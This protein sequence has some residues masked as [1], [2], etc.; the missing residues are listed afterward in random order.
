[1]SSLQIIS[2]RDKCIFIFVKFEIEM[3]ANTRPKVSKS[4]LAQTPYR[5]CGICNKAV[6]R[7]SSK[8]S[9]E[10]TLRRHRGKSKQCG[11]MIHGNVEEDHIFEDGGMSPVT[12]DDPLEEDFIETQNVLLSAQDVGLKVDLSKR[13]DFILSEMDVDDLCKEGR[14]NCIEIDAVSPSIDILEKQKKLELFFDSRLNPKPFGN[15]RSPGGKA[16]TPFK[17]EDDADLLKL[18][19]SCGLSDNQ[20]DLMIETF[21]KILDRWEVRIPIH[22]D[23]TYMRSKLDRMVSEHFPI[24]TKHFPF[25][26]D[27]FGEYI[28][29][30]P[31]KPMIGTNFDIK[32]ILAE[33]LLECDPSLFLTEFNGEHPPQGINAN[34]GNSPMWKA[35]CD[36]MNLYPKIE[37]QSPIPICLVISSDEAMASRSKSEQ[38]LDFGILNCVGT[39]F[40]KHL[41]GY[42]PLNLPYSEATL[43]QLLKDRGIN[44]KTDHERILRWTK[45]K[46]MMEFIFSVF[47]PVTKL[48][49]N[50]FEVLIGQGA[51][52]IKRIAFFHVL[53]ISGDGMF[54]DGIAGT[55]MRRLGMQCRLCTTRKMYGLTEPV[56]GYV[57]RD[58]FEHAWIVAQLEEVY[59]KRWC[60]FVNKG[61]EEGSLYKYSLQD[62]EFLKLGKQF[63]LVEG[64]NCL[65]KFF[66]YWRGR[67][68]SSLHQAIPPDFLHVIEKG[69]LEKTIQW[70]LVV[71][72]LVEEI[73]RKSRLEN[74]TEG[75]SLLDARIISFPPRQ[76]YWFSR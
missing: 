38:P 65:Y 57:Y 3:L 68:I 7:F 67:G 2:F 51:D 4:V 28:R 61:A 11:I 45:R 44:F 42:N 60:W 75:N 66:G 50:C 41:V 76:S 26:K 5:V 19:T 17:W 52:Q 8:D 74:Y 13:S 43:I 25:N 18:A 12:D 39:S 15:L 21:Q 73:S 20:G 16:G 35:I 34:F 1:M 30:Q 9:W 47:D 53:L 32:S 63:G 56:G 71:V 36:D 22:K 37:G 62:K 29:G 72:G 49:E 23:F 40:K 59:V 24:E 64:R 69:F 6:Y 27:I 33:A 46:A 10:T 31:M 58:D 48:G 55:G 54:L 70:S 14:F